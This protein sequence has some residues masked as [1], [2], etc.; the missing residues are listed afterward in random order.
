MRS[1]W[2]MYWKST[3]DGRSP[4]RIHGPGVSRSAASTCI[5][6]PS[7]NGVAAAWSTIAHLA[8]GILK[9]LAAKGPW[10]EHE[11]APRAKQ[12]A[13]KL[14]QLVRP[15]APVAGHSVPLSVCHAPGRRQA[16]SAS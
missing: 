9:G 2:E 3:S 16:A 15:A 10:L 5:A 6:S 7:E 1:T 11:A 4:P 13:L 14:H 12:V 8:Q